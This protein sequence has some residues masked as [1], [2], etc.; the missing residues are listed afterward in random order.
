M[1]PCEQSVEHLVVVVETRPERAR[2]APLAGSKARL[3]VAGV[4]ALRLCSICRKLLRSRGGAGGRSFSST[5]N[6]EPRTPPKSSSGTRAWEAMAWCGHGS[7]GLAGRRHDR[8]GYRRGG[9]GDVGRGRRRKGRGR[10]K[11][12]VSPMGG[13]GGQG[14]ASRPSACVCL[15]ANAA[16]SWAG[17]ELKVDKKQNRWLLRVGPPFVSVFPQ[18]DAAE[19]FG[20]ARWSC[21]NTATV[22]R[23]FGSSRSCSSGTC[24]L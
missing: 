6:K 13:P 9:D 14:C 1:V 22:T 10:V 2:R 3:A 7:D 4:G 12:V 16:Q 15:A 21:P 5:G 18:T 11:L 23:S 8:G 20:V 24:M 19:P 17:N